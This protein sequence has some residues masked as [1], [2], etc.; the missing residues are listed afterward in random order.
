MVK[1]V[2][3][4]SAG[5]VGREILEEFLSQDKTALVDALQGVDIVPSFSVPIDDPNNQARKTLIDACV[6]A[7]VCRFASS[8][9]AA[10]SHGED[11]YVWR[12]ELVQYV[13]IFEKQTRRKSYHHKNT[14]VQIT[15]TSVQDLAKVVASAVDDEG[16]WPELSGVRGNQRFGSFASDTFVVESAEMRD[17]ELGRF[18][19]SWFPIIDYPAVPEDQRNAFSQRYFAAFILAFERGGWDASNEWSELLLDFQFTGTEE[20]LSRI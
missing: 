15:L 5:N 8:E 2:L 6:E 7:G 11:L 9:W 14:K 4:G 19:S 12:L 17:L 16:A 3:A 10:G 1:F 20:F 13:T 18:T